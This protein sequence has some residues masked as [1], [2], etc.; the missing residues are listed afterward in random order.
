MARNKGE[1]VRTT[2]LLRVDAKLRFRT[3]AIFLI[4]RLRVVSIAVMRARIIIVHNIVRK[5]EN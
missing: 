3:C 2:D 4:L 1:N 5:S